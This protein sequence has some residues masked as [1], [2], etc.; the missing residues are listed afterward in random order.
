M[1]NTSC[2]PLLTFTNNPDDDRRGI[3]LGS[4]TGRAKRDCPV[5]VRMWA[6]QTV[7]CF[8]WMT[9]TSLRATRAGPRQA[10]CAEAI[11]TSSRI[12]SASSH[13]F[14]GARSP[15]RRTEPSFTSHT[16]GAALS[17]LTWYDRAGKELGRVGDI[18]VVANPTLSPDGSRLAIDI[19]DAKANNVN[20]WLSDLNRG[21]NSRFTFDTSE[22]VG[23]VWSRD[24]TLIAY[25]SLQAKRYKSFS[26]TGARAAASPND[27]L[28]QSKRL[29]PRMIS[30]RTPGRS[31]ISY[32]SPRCSPPR[33]DLSW[34]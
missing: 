30:F 2:S 14:T 29:T 5:A 26:E 1:A 15:W 8:I 27:F 19:A 34:C 17:V 18:G 6:T 16:V 33:E 24:G 28:C 3:Y 21:T 12:R 9:R 25:R 23:G 10:N 11:R 13:P 22:D 31:T 7:T 20:I 32:S 4:L